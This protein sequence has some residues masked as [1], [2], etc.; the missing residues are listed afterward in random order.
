MVRHRSG[1]T[2]E[3]LSIGAGVSS[4]LVGSRPGRVVGVFSSGLY[5]VSDSHIFAVADQRVPAGPVHLIVDRPIGPVRE[6]TRVQF[7]GGTIDIGTVRIDLHNVE[8][9]RPAHPSAADLEVARPILAAVLTPDQVV[10]DLT[11]V[12]HEAMTCIA[13]RDLHRLQTLTGGRGGGLTPSGDDLL[14]GVVLFDAFENPHP[15]RLARRVELMARTKTT[16]L[17]LTFLHWAAIGHSIAPV[18]ALFD[19]AT[20]GEQ[21]AVRDVV[22]AVDRVG[23]SSGRALLAG[24]AAAAQQPSGRCPSG[25]FVF[26]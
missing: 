18:H 22:G 23:G 4:A 14:A 1:Q 20:T 3:A 10:P 15:S 7:S 24:I 17:S 8:P 13:Q 26:N 21:Q 19:A 5:V 12:W 11:S 25:Q 9:W 6:G 16:N 2:L